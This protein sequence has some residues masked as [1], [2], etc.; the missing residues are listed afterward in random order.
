MCRQEPCLHGSPQRSE[1]LIGPDPAVFWPDLCCIRP[2]GEAGPIPASPQARLSRDTPEPFDQSDRPRTGPSCL[3]GRH[4]RG[5]RAVGPGR[6]HRIS[7]TDRR[8]PAAAGSLFALLQRCGPQKSGLHGP[9]DAS[10]AATTSAEPVR[11]LTSGTRS[12]A[13]WA[14]AGL[15]AFCLGRDGAQPREALQTVTPS[16]LG[17]CEAQHGSPSAWLGLIRAGPA[18]ASRAALAPQGELRT[19][20]P[21]AET[22]RHAAG[23]ATAIEMRQVQRWRLCKRAGC[24]RQRSGRSPGRQRR[25]GP[26]ARGPCADLAAAAPGQQPGRESGA[27]GGAQDDVP[28]CRTKTGR[29]HAG[30]FIDGRNPKPGCHGRHDR[31]A[32]GSSDCNNGR[33]RRTRL[34][35][36]R[37]AAGRRR[38][39]TVSA[40]LAAVGL[41]VENDQKD[42]RNQDEQEAG[43][44]TEVVGFHG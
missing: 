7:W 12:A 26:P 35:G 22:A 18:A 29:H 28:P 43:N 34:D 14:T 31:Q 23:Q 27:D 44:E 16:R 42:R 5:C 13:L 6:C 8:P 3:P 32:E 41:D 33:R 19:D 4:S 39:G 25:E 10:E 40:A 38:R 30:E 11:W 37:R 24:V 9:Q 15:E 36:I 20:G 17:A 21:R 1:G 2:D